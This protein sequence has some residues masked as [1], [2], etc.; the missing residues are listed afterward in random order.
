MRRGKKFIRTLI[1]FCLSVILIPFVLPGSAIALDK[2]EKT[3]VAYMDISF[4]CG[5]H[6]EGTGTMIAVNGML[7]AGHNLVCHTHSKGIEDCTFYFNR[8]GN[9]YFYK[10]NGSFS[11]C[12]Y[13]DF[14]SGYS[15]INDIG[16]IV[17]PKD[18]GKTTGWYASRVE[19]DSDLIDEVCYILGYNGPYLAF[20]RGRVDV[21][22][23]KQISW[24]MSTSYKGASEGGPVYYGYEGLVYPVLVAVY[25]SFSDT[26]SYGWRVF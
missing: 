9:S 20:D 24:H 8:N 11:Y 7:T 26:G 3:A 17:F 21:E 23:S 4:K 14:S 15:S 6:R 16:Y 5:C 10:Y 22:S 2:S 1:L 19:S 13:D 25:T 12:S 18:I